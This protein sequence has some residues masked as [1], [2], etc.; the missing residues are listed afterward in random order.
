MRNNIHLFVYIFFVFFYFIDICEPQERYKTYIVKKTDLN[1]PVSPYKLYFVVNI[2][3]FEKEYSLGII[4]LRGEKIL[5]NPVGQKEGYT[6]EGFFSKQLK[7][8]ILPSS[9][10]VT[11]QL[12]DKNGKSTHA[13]LP[14]F[15]RGREQTYYTVITLPREDLARSWLSFYFS[16]IDG[17]GTKEYVTFELDMTEYNWPQG[18]GNVIYGVEQEKK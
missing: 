9:Y 3:L 7:K 5:Y 1:H 13:W 4:I 8:Q 16:D 11:W 6:R 17:D 18:I 10:T 2:F 12:R 15:F 14:L